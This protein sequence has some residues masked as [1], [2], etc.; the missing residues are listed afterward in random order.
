MKYVMFSYKT[1]F[2]HPLQKFRYLVVG[3]SGYSTY[4]DL[5]QSNLLKSY[6]ESNAAMSVCKLLVCFVEIW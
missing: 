6:P 1:P 5:V 4:G 2:L 3:I